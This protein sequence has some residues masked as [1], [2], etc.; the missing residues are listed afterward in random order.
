MHVAFSSFPPAVLAVEIQASAVAMKWRNLFPPFLSL[1]PRPLFYSS[2]LLQSF[3]PCLVLPPKCLKGR[4]RNE[5]S[6]QKKVSRGEIITMDALFFVRTF[7]C[8][9]GEEGVIVDLL[10]LVFVPTL[11]GGRTEAAGHAL[12]TS[13]LASPHPIPPRAVV[14]HLCMHWRLR[15]ATSDHC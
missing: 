9:Q 4:R 11:I 13:P 15:R 8:T 7:S 3:P 5:F 2:A 6:R 12:S 10:P 1:Q 14:Y